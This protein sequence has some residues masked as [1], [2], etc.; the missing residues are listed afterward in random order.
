MSGQISWSLKLIRLTCVRYR[1]TSVTHPRLVPRNRQLLADT[2]VVLPACP[3]K[4]FKSNR[5]WRE[6]QTAWQQRTFDVSN[7]MI[8]K[9]HSWRASLTL[10][11]AFSTAL[12]SDSSWSFS[13]SYLNVTFC[14]PRQHDIQRFPARSSWLFQTSKMTERRA[15]AAEGNIW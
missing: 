14:L 13:Y 12:I 9:T 5:N 3:G 6:R 10:S 15:K 11:K 2:S 1:E 4:A 7:K 8:Q